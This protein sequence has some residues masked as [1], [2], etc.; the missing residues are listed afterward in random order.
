MHRHVSSVVSSCYFHIR[1]LHLIRP[2]LTLAAAVSVA[3]SIIG[4]HLDYC[5]NML[6]ET[7]QRHLDRLQSVQNSLAR[8]VSATEL[9]RQMHW[10]PIRQCVDFKLG[11]ITIQSHPH[12]RAELFGQ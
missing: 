11:F 5:N 8:A 7:L 12:W 4:S 9:R 1:T 2:G 6:C 10:L 3:V